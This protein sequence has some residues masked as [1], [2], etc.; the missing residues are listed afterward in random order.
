MD[1]DRGSGNDWDSEHLIAE[2]GIGPDFAAFIR[3]EF[4]G[5]VIYRVLDETWLST[6]TDSRRWEGDL[7]SFARV[8]E[9]DDFAELHSLFFE[10]APEA[11]HYQFV[12]GSAC[13]DV[14]TAE[15]PTASLHHREET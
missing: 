6:S 14:I 1:Y 2:F 10:L 15:L 4:D 3:I 7:T 5:P 9:G 13:L 8:V 11:R 12:T